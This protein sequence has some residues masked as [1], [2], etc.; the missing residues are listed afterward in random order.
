[1]SPVQQASLE[2]RKAYIQQIEILHYIDFVR[3]KDDL[4]TVVYY[5]T[6]ALQPSDQH[7]L[8][9]ITIIKK[10]YWK[11][12][13]FLTNLC[14]LIKYIMKYNRMCVTEKLQLASSYTWQLMRLIQHF[15]L[16][17]TIS[18][19]W[20]FNN[21]WLR[22]DVYFGQIMRQNMLLVTFMWK[23]HSYNFCGA[24]ETVM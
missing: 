17:I 1:M 21:F 3:K 23:I 19:Y 9:Y 16:N 14:D 18:H 10:Y 5:F 11:I 13:P 7:V 2:Y 15:Y 4:N 8:H 12:K 22:S 24:E 20:V 6:L